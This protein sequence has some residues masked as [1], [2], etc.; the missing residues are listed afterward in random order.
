MV[1][2][3]Y[4]NGIEIARRN[5]AGTPSWDAGAADQHLDM[6][7]VSLEP[8]AVPNFVSLLRRDGN[9]LAIH[10]LNTSST[11]SDFLISAELTATVISSDDTTSSMQT[12]VGPVVLEASAPVKARA[13]AGA[14]WTAMN[15]AVFAVGPSRRDSADQRTDVPPGRLTGI[16]TIPTPNTSS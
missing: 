15:E 10:G 13:R 12:Y 6:D 11:S 16:P 3:A 4:L 9:V 7:A 1:F 14:N 8:I 5:A 2:V